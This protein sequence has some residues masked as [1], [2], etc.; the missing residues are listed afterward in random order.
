M[1]IVPKDE[2][3]WTLRLR[4]RKW[5]I[6]ALG[7]WTHEFRGVVKVVTGAGKTL[8]A[9]MCM[10]AFREKYP[11]GRVVIVVPTVALLDQWYVSLTED[12]V[13]PEHD[14][15]CFSGE[16]KPGTPKP[17]NILVINT[18]RHVFLR[19]RRL[20]AFHLCQNLSA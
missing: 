7:R 14:I 9:E 16:D 1:T 10:N 11:R 17:I 19:G 5:Q 12:L 4:P 2:R 6:E 3:A 18:A 20:R 13:V 8:F 15:A